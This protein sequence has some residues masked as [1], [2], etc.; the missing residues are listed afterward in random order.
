FLLPAMNM[1][2]KPAETREVIDMLLAHLDSDKLG[3]LGASLGYLDQMVDADYAKEV[4]G[5]IEK[6]GKNLP[7]LGWIAFHRGEKT[8]RSEPVKSEAYVTTKATVAAAIAK[9]GDKR[10]QSQFDEL[11]VEVE[12][13]GIGMAAPEITGVDL[14]GVAF[15]LSDYRGKVV[16]LD[17]WGDW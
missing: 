5:K 9:A 3:Q 16:F 2:E 15:K 11:V 12:K 14:D 13:F 4:M 6:H 1:G 17:F 8:L 7:L 10:L